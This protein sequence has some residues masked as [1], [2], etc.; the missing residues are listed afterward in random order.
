MLQLAAMAGSRQQ[1][2][3]KSR[4]ILGKVYSFGRTVIDYDRC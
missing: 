4:H 3:P 1:T 2:V